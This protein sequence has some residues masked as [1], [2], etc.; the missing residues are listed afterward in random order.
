MGG[1]FPYCTGCLYRPAIPRNGPNPH[2][3]QKS[4]GRLEFYKFLSSHKILN[5]AHKRPITEPKKRTWSLLLS[6]TSCHTH[7]LQI[8]G[9]PH[10]IA[11]QLKIVPMGYGVRGGAR[12]EQG[13]ERVAGDQLTPLIKSKGERGEANSQIMSCFQLH[14]W[15]V[16][17]SC[18]S[19]FLLSPFCC[20][21]LSRYKKGSW[22]Q[23]TFTIW[24]GYEGDMLYWELACPARYTPDQVYKTIGNWFPCKMLY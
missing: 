15:Y 23:T 11:R 21:S 24:L 13:G 19:L 3:N 12:W 4:G 1:P 6:N 9:H 20:R 18:P 5:S 2:G 22:N 10:D 7:N 14:P 17:Y 8:R 16:Q